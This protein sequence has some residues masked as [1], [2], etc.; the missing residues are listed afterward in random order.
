[1]RTLKRP[2]EVPGRLPNGPPP[3][4]AAD[5]ELPGDLDDATKLVMAQARGEWASLLGTP[6]PEEHARFRWMPST[7]GKAVPQAGSTP[8]ARRW[9]A[10]AA[11]VD[12]CVRLLQEPWSEIGLRVLQRHMRLLRSTINGWPA[13]DPQRPQAKSLVAAAALH[14]D[15][16]MRR[17]ADTGCG[18][19]DF[20]RAASSV[21]RVGRVKAEKLEAASRTSTHTGFKT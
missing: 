2:T 6:L 20:C 4:P 15:M 18:H 14:L 17:A 13:E 7:G 19:P 21:A 1:M 10:L 9:R 16:A 12:D 5:L 11:R 8:L 3:P